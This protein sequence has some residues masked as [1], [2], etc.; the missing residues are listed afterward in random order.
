M[1]GVFSHQRTVNS[2]GVLFFMF[3]LI[4]VSLQTA[5]AQ[6]QKSKE[7][8]KSQDEVMTLK[9]HLVTMDV[10]VKDKKGKYLTDL[11]AQEFSIVENGVQQRVEFFD[12]P[13]VGAGETG[14]P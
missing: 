10:M 11:K 5:Q 3:A 6:E 14:Q 1:P 9:T 4:A 2:P 7:S 8:Q 13:L 12:P